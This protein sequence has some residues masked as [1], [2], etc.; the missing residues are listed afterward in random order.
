MSIPFLTPESKKTIIYLPKFNSHIDINNEEIK[1]RIRRGGILLSKTLDTNTVDEEF[2]TR[3]RKG[4]ISTTLDM[5]PDNE[6]LIPKGGISTTLDAKP[7]EE[8]LNSRTRKRGI[9][10]INFGNEERPPKG[11]IS[12][13]LDTIPDNEERPPPKGG[14]STTLDKNLLDNSM[15]PKIFKCNEYVYTIFINNVVVGFT[16]NEECAKT[17]LMKLS[18]SL[19]YSTDKIF[20]DDKKIEIYRD[21]LWSSKIVYIVKYEKTLRLI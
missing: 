12:T 17:Y 2:V 7:V 4:G 8:D 18:S 13:T 21:S 15:D 19:I 16:Y 10:D 1:T 6:E 11:C 20:K 3:T 14:I 5:I 9:L